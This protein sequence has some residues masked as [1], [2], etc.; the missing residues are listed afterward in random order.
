MEFIDHTSSEKDSI[1]TPG[2]MCTLTGHRL[3]YDPEDEKQGL[4]FVAEDGNEIKVTVIGQ[5]TSAK[6]MFDVPKELV[7]GEYQLV[8]RN[9][10][11]GA[12]DTE[13]TVS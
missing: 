10:L 8:V 4:F 12:L 1:A 9:G 5:N 3:K 7:S 11:E 2:G 13:L 6:L